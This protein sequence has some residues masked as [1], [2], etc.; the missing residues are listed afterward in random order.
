M[1]DQN[2]V[3][4][5]ENAKER[6]DALLNPTKDDLLIEETVW[7][8]IHPLIE[9]VEDFY[10]SKMYN[11][12][13]KSMFDV[14]FIPF[15][16]KSIEI[17][18]IISKRYVD[19]I[20]DK[21]PKTKSAYTDGKT[22]YLPYYIFFPEYYKYFHHVHDPYMMVLSAIIHFNGFIVHESAHIPK[23]VCEMMQLVALATT[24]PDL[25]KSTL[26]HSVVNVVE[27]LHIES[28]AKLEDPR[29]FEFNNALNNLYFFPDTVLQ[30]CYDSFMQEASL[31]N[32]IDLFT[33]MKGSNNIGDLRFDVIAEAHDKA[34]DVLDLSLNQKQR[35]K[36]AKEVWD[37]LVKASIEQ[38]AEQMM[39]NGESQE[40]AQEKA[41]QKIDQEIKD[42]N[43]DKQD[44][45]GQQGAGNIDQFEEFSEALANF[46]Q[47]VM[48]G[49]SD[50]DKNKIQQAA[51]QMDKQ[52]QQ[53]VQ[54]ASQKEQEQK[55]NKPIIEEEHL[56]PTETIKTNERAVEIA[57]CMRYNNQT[58]KL[59]LYPRRTEFNGFGNKLKNVRT[60]RP[61]RPRPVKEGFDLNE[62]SLWRYGMDNLIFG[63]KNGTQPVIDDPE[64]IMLIDISGS[65]ETFI[66][67]SKLMLK[68]DM[69]S[70]V[71][72]VYNDMLN[73]R[74]P[75]SVYCHSSGGFQNRQ[76]SG[77]KVYGIA[78]H[79]MR[80]VSGPEIRSTT[81]DEQRFAMIRELDSASNYD[82]WAI[83]TVGNL[84][85]VRRKPKVLI[86]WSDGA[87][88]GG[89]SG[90]SAIEHT[91]KE[92]EKLRRKGILV[93][94]MS[95]VE[96]VVENNNE[97]YGKEF[98]FR[99]FGE[100]LPKETKR[101][102]T[103]VAKLTAPKGQ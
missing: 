102:V 65:T 6:Q 77:C 79:N 85:S 90:M 81:H 97:I 9:F 62:N 45:N 30:R 91:K 92:I 73:A 53:Q 61:E 94:S 75:V 95:V 11:N 17:G 100:N 33:C 78:S 29:A 34:L 59:E 37:L 1:N 44:E 71:Q 22:I 83:E 76:G 35:C 64:T 84:F 8:D 31:T 98:N 89:L 46:L 70:A 101:V 56:P 67:G 14:Q 27:D 93:L 63:K 10:M 58:M 16:V 21:N 23:S 20:V 15:L 48:D 36:I 13:P 41:Q 69:A 74:M 51:Q 38:T 50:E 25:Q 42:S 47:E 18:K 32:A 54:Q 87:P 80:F 4:K 55:R 72:T 52:L 66:N 19:V 57:D 43:F 24:D 12:L 60:P 82:G 103:H 99:A 7:G 96:E 26:F 3:P 88:S 40:D 2:P 86:V 28:Y 5:W 49:M 68:D 39:Q